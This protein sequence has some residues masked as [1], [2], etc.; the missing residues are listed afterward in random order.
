MDLAALRERTGAFLARYVE[1]LAD[2]SHAK[3]WTRFLERL[4]EGDFSD[5]LGSKLAEGLLNQLDTLLRDGAASFDYNR[6]PVRLSGRDAQDVIGFLGYIART[7]FT[8]GLREAAGCYRLMSAYEAAYE[9]AVRSNGRLSFGDVQV[10]LSRARENGVKMDIDYRLDGQFNHWMLDEFQDTSTR[11]WSVIGN[12]ADEI[13]QSDAGRRTFFYVGDVKQ[14]IY[15]WR[16]GDSTLFEAVQGYYRELFGDEPGVLATSWRSSPVILTAVNRVFGGNLDKPLGEFGEV[17]RR[18]RRNWQEHHHAPKNEKLPGRVE[19]YALDKPGKDDRPDI[20]RP[21]EMTCRIVED[22]RRRK[23]PSIAVLVRINSFGDRIADALRA[24][25]VDVRRETNP[26]L[27]DNGVI[28]ALLSMLQLADHPGD[29]FALKHLKMTP[30]FDVLQDWS[31]RGDLPAAVRQAAAAKGIAGL[32]GDLL[33]L[34]RARGLLSDPFVEIRARQLTDAA[35]EFDRLSQG[36]PSDF[37]RHARS[38]EVKDPTPAGGVVV[39]TVHKAK[40][41]E[42][43]A[44]ILPDLQGSRREFTHLERG[45]L[46]P[47]SAHPAG[48]RPGNNPADPEPDPHGFVFPLP[49]EHIARLDHVL[50]H[51]RVHARNNRV[52]EELCLLYVAMTRARQALYLVTEEPAK[53]GHSLHASTIL[54]QTL[55]GAES[56]PLPPDG[57]PGQLV[58]SDGAPDWHNP[59]SPSAGP[60]PA[61]PTAEPFAPGIKAG[62]SAGRRLIVTTPSGEETPQRRD[63]SVLFSAG[64]R[65]GSS[66]GNA[67]HELFEQIEWFEEGIGER[68][69]AAWNPSPLAL[70]PELRD[71]VRDEFLAA[72]ATPGIRDILSH[73]AGAAEVWREQ[74]F[75]LADQGKWIT[76][77]MDRVMVERDTKGRP[78]RATVIDFK[79]DRVSSDEELGEHVAMYRP[80]LAWYLKALSR[81]LGLPGNRLR[82]ALVFTHARRTVIETPSAAE[83]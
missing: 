17:V 14:A 62:A 63:A 46:V 72:L 5:A 27:M 48:K 69:L 6:K 15:G 35:M 44:V 58:Y 21:I 74:A 82:A 49:G 75:E 1:P 78:V 10:V 33:D 40:G 26:S 37:A 70:A 80:Q 43:D 83:N 34:C 13:L 4:L 67:L 64:T 31:A 11:Q 22:L 39:M 45:E 30:L 23:V 8:R 66:R 55:G 28:S 76:G 2:K 53:D 77:R 29:E 12:L 81:L 24:R 71:E 50:S 60:G 38:L 36:G 52:Y 73:P 25:G 7:E 68:V 20:A 61:L 9:N 54:Q 16:G 42:D 32:L 57:P 19:L 51:A 41:L 47:F 59:A 56:Q 79:S 3:A 18:W 65:S